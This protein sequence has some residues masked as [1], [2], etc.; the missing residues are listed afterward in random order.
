MS[1]K[2]ENII[3][4]TSDDGDVEVEVID[5]TVIDGKT[6]LLVADADVEEGDCYILKDI[7]ESTDDE[8]NYE[9]VSDEEADMVFEVFEKMLNEEIDLKK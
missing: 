5:Q 7:S 6:Y 1:K 8:A 3:T 2:I 4:M 9:V